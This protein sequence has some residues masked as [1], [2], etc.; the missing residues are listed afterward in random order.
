VA[1]K[2]C[3]ITDIDYATKT[4]TMEWINEAQIKRFMSIKD[5]VLF[6]GSRRLYIFNMQPPIVQPPTDEEWYR[7]YVDQERA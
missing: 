3:A 7:D 5:E 6:G 1:A 4:V 2:V